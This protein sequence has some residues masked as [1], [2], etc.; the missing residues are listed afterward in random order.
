MEAGCCGGMGAIFSTSSI[1][2][3]SKTASFFKQDVKSLGFFLYKSAAS[4]REEKIKCNV[5]SHF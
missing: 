2:C 5:L 4:K 3:F 1:V